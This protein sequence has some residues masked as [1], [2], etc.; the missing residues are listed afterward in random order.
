MKITRR[1]RLINYLIKH[2]K[3]QKYLEIGVRNPSLNFDFINCIQKDGVDSDVNVRCRYRMKSDDFFKKISRNK[4]Y[5]IIFIDGEH[6]YKQVLKDVE[7]SLNHLNFGGTI[8]LHDCNPISEIRQR[9]SLYGKGKC[10]GTV[11]KAFALLR[12]TREDL[13]MY[14]V[15]IDHGCGIIQKGKQKLFPKVSKSKLTYYFLKKHRNKI[16]KLCSVKQFRRKIKG[17]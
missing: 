3:Y 7:N 5:D 12:M 2:N 14:V 11:W 15:D 17:R 1:T 8:V 9:E 13:N 16:L 4:K 6:L 10:N